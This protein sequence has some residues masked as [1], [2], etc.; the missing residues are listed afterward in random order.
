LYTTNPDVSTGDGLA[1]GWR[2]GCRVANM[3]FVQFHPTCLYH[4][5]DTSFLISEALR[6]E[7]GKLT[8]PNGEAFMKYYDK[9]GDLAPRDIVARAIDF[10]MKK[11]GLECVYLDISEKTKSF[12][13][14][15]GLWNNIQEINNLYKAV[16]TLSILLS[17]FLNIFNSSSFVNFIPII[18]S[19]T[20]NIL[21]ISIRS[22]SKV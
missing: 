15:I 1:M 12:Y 21:N 9:R 4:S 18:L 22:E 16:N 7:G 11:R 20:L 5:K 13:E 14:E 10:E 6:G 19:K 2:A 8:L 3:E 17:I